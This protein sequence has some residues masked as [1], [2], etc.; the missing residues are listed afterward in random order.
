MREEFKIVSR[1][2][3]PHKHI[4][5]IGRDF[6]GKIYTYFLKIH[7]W[8]PRFMFELQRGISEFTSEMILNFVKD[9]VYSPEYDW[10]DK[11]LA[12]YDLKYYD[13]WEL[14]KAM[15]GECGYDD[16]TIDED[17][18]NAEVITIVPQNVSVL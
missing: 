13:A 7:E 12:A 11:V 10:I 3:F 17:Y 18:E 15:K 5:T 16:L 9:R 6:N 14:F 2:K 8:H 1:R 4:A